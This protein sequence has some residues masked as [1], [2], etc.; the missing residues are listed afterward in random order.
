MDLVLIKPAK[1][2]FSNLL[3]GV[4]STKLPP[5]SRRLATARV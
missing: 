5:E 4:A 1:K 2:G 3:I